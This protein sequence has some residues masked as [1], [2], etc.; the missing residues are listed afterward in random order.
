MSDDVRART[1]VATPASGT[2]CT[3][4]GVLCGMGA[5]P[6][7]CLAGL[8]PLL[9]CTP[10]RA[11]ADS[12][13]AR[14]LDSGGGGDTGALDACPEGALA[15]IDL[16]DGRSAEDLAEVGGYAYAWTDD[17]VIIVVRLGDDAWAALSAVCTHQG[18]F[19]GYRIKADDLFCGCH[20]SIFQ[21][22]GSVTAGPAK[23]PL[24]VYAVE[25]Q[26]DLLVVTG[27]V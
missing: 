25:H 19:V 5:A 7:L 8:P 4:R 3:R 21:L 27:P 11:A 15:C 2:P 13:G 20:A 10:E 6:V 1:E 14:G 23:T 12:G 18:C 17:D 24:R 22:D 26:G 9:A 16:S